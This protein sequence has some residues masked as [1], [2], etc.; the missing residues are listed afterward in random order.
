[1]H[2]YIEWGAL[3]HT[4]TLEKSHTQ[5]HTKYLQFF[6]EREHMLTKSCAIWHS[7]FHYKIDYLVLL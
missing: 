6:K 4:C 5:L 1:M 7:H 2:H 3:I